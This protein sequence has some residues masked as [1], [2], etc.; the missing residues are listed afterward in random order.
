MNRVSPGVLAPPHEVLTPD[1]WRSRGREQRGVTSRSSHAQWSP[2]K[3]R[4]D[5]TA[6]N[7]VAGLLG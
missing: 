6:I 4:P 7:L 3:E 2:P 5:P 1:E